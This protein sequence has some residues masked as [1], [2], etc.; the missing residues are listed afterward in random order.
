MTDKT[1]FGGYKWEAMST[2]YRFE[3]THAFHDSINWDALCQYASKLNK[4]EPCTMDSPT[5]RGGRNLIRVLKFQN[6]TRWIARFRIP[7]KDNY[8]FEASK[9]VL[10]QEVDCMQLVKDRTSVPVP[11]VFGYIASHENDIGGSFI[12]ME[13]LFGNAAVNL[14]HTVPMSS[15]QRKSFYDQ[16]AKFQVN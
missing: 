9:R 12:L 15:E 16:M 5:T 13:C 10:Q 3:E 1:N 6:G 11:T 14:H 8:D 4:G 7:S 2:S